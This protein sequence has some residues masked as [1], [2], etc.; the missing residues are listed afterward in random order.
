MDKFESKCN[1]INGLLKTT[2]KY[3]VFVTE[4]GEELNV[5]AQGPAPTLLHMC[6]RLCN[7]VRKNL[8]EHMPE[9]LVD[10]LMKSVIKTD[11]EIDEDYEK[12]KSDLDDK[13]IPDW[14]KKL[15]DMVDEEED[16]DDST[17]EADDDEEEDEDEDDG[18]GTNPDLS[19]RVDLHVHSGDDD[20]E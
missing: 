9:R 12:L 11:D 1:A 17:D 3:F 14:L 20:C 15:M 19:V 8:E 13:T 2:C 6:N 4:D 5:Q 10:D 18:D 16:E 7:A